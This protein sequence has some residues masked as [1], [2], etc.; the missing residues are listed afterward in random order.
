MDPA[1]TEKSGS[2]P[3]LIACETLVSEN[4][5]VLCAV[6]VAMAES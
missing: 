4:C 3:T 5:R 1:E 2:G 6:A